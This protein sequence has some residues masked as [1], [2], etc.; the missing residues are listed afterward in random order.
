MIVATDMGKRCVNGDFTVLIYQPNQTFQTTDD[1]CSKFPLGFK[2]KSHY[3]KI[4]T[5]YV[6]KNLN[7]TLQTQPQLF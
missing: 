6:I 3:N 2:R 5:S 1:E 4:L 7:T